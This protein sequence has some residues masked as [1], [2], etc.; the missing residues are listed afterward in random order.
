[1]NKNERLFSSEADGKQSLLGLLFDPE[2]GGDI[3]LRNVA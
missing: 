1:L 2:S 3:L